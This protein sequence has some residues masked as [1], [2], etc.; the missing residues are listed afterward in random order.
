MQCS[1]ARKTAIIEWCRGECWMRLLPRAK[2]RYGLRGGLHANVR[3][4]KGVIGKT[5]S[6]QYSIHQH[7][8]E[9]NLATL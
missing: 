2:R 1:F 5:I 8:H 9:C 4:L 7:V 6:S 3:I